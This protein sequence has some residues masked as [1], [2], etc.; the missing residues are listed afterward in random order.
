MRFTTPLVIDGLTWSVAVEEP[1]NIIEV[2]DV[3]GEART[4]LPDFVTRLRWEPGSEVDLQLAFVV[5]KLGFQPEGLRVFT[6]TGYGLNFSGHLRLTDDDNFLFQFV[7]GEGIGSYWGIPD[8]A[9]S[10]PM[11]GTVLPVVAFMVGL[12]HNWTADLA[13]NITYSRSRIDNTAFQRGDDLHAT[14]YF[15]ANLIWTVT[16]QLSVGGEYLYGTRVDVDG[17]AGAAN[18][19]EFVATWLLP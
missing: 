2:P 6:G 5:R 3:P 16:E 1:V 14:E 15:A 12:G 17:S 13:S 7:G 10:G 19:L 11:R 8:V 18:R 9:P 4:P